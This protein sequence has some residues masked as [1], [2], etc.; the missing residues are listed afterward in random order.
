[1][2]FMNFNKNFFSKKSPVNLLNQ[3]LFVYFF[4]HP[5]LRDSFFGTQCEVHIYHAFISH[6]SRYSLDQKKVSSRSRLGHSRVSSR[7]RLGQ[8]GKRLGLVSVSGAQVSVSVLVSTQKVLSPSLGSNIQPWVIE[9]PKGQRVKVTYVS[10]G[11]KKPRGSRVSHRCSAANQG[12]MIDK[13]GR[14]NVSVCEGSEG[15]RLEDDQQYYLSE[16]SVL[17]VIL[18]LKREDI[19][20]YLLK[21]EGAVYNKLLSFFIELY[22]LF[23]PISYSKS[24][25]IQF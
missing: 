16:G 12:I 4:F 9:S 22:Y 8:F 18:N 19:N 7:S 15:W 11:S 23:F 10:I 14:R 3:G 20:K 1:M 13:L 6:V 17:Q 5:S 25:F 24:L 2:F 21:I